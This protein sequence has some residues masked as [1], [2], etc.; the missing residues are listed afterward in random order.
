MKSETT[1]VSSV[2]GLFFKTHGSFRLPCGSINMR[3]KRAQTM[4]IVLLDSV[5]RMVP[6]GYLTNK[7]NRIKVN[8]SSEP[9]CW[10][11]DDSNSIQ[12]YSWSN[13][14]WSHYLLIILIMVHENYSQT[15]FAIPFLLVPK[16]IRIS[17]ILRMFHQHFLPLI[18]ET[19]KRR[20]RSLLCFPS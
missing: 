9:T 5:H 8:F 4:E 12:F 16:S 3:C 7:T 13:F 15:C 1:S 2:Y 19:L 18:N 14:L 11:K 10:T 20:S 17:R 6:K